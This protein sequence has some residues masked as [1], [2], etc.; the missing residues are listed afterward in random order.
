M[1]LPAP[2]G[3]YPVGAGD[4]EW[5]RK[6]A[7]AARPHGPAGV[8]CRIYY[9]GAPHPP[10][11]EAKEP[12]RPASSGKKLPWLPSSSY[13]HGYALY[14]FGA[15]SPPSPSAPSPLEDI[16]L[17]PTLA[18]AASSALRHAML[19]AFGSLFSW[20][21]A[22]DT[23]ASH[24]LELAPRPYL[25]PFP[26]LVFSHGL[27]GMRTTYSGL[28]SDLAS[29]GFVVL[30]LEHRDGSACNTHLSEGS[31]VRPECAHTARGGWLP[32][33]KPRPDAADPFEERLRRGQLAWRVGEAAMALDLAALLEAGSPP[34]N[35]APGCDRLADALSFKG[36]IDLSRPL[37]AGHSMGGV[38]AFACARADP[39]YKG[40]VC[41][42]PFWMPLS[43]EDYD[44]PAHNTPLLIINA[45]GFAW[46]KQTQCV[47]AS[48]LPFPERPLFCFDS[49]PARR[50]NRIR[51]GPSNPPGIRVPQ[52]DE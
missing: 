45:D 44:P 1:P 11:L 52:E 30:A 31:S 3:P 19:L 16:P 47:G 13:G 36:R 37:V 14:M 6:P 5:V 48:L 42:D 35:A 17:R 4:F 27:A 28:C 20:F 18:G 26:V 10:P 43:P 12:P 34:E 39:R 38:T 46:E 2:S 25:Q 51:F 32:Y 41:L 24:A 23:A 50:S 33:H 29:H 22:A 21:G 8:F 15:A 49:A 40:V 9:P 7:P